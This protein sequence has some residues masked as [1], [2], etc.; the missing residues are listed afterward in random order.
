MEESTIR[1]FE[2]LISNY[3]ET[4]EDIKRIKY[5]EYIDTMY[6]MQIKPFLDDVTE[7]DLARIEKCYRKMMLIRLKLPITITI[8]NSE[9]TD[10]VLQ[11]SLDNLL[12]QESKDISI[13]PQLREKTSILDKIKKWFHTG[14]C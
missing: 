10:K 2:D 4:D 9:R 1:S 11:D 12:N 3:D 6:Y 7:Y 14:T 8:P 13:G 5:S